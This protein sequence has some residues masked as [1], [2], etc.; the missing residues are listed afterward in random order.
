[1]SGAEIGK[2]ERQLMTTL[3]LQVL[4]APDGG[5][6]M[7]GKYWDEVERRIEVQRHLAHRLQL[8]LEG[9]PCLR[10]VLQSTSVTTPARL[11]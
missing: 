11:S 9:R 5:G 10:R 4:A 1:M 2:R 7:V 3:I 8:G 6:D